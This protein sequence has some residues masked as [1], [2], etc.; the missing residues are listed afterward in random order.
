[1]QL[2]QLKIGEEALIEEVAY[3]NVYLKLLDMGCIPGERILVMFEAPLGDPIAVKVSGYVL[4]MRKAEAG[5]I[6]VR[7]L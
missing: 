6:K 5:S 2:S 7:K 1:M 3:S 4:S